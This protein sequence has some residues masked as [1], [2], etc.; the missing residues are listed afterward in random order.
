[1]KLF[2]YI[3]FIAIVCSI[4]LSFYGNVYSIS[5]KD[6]DT[7][8][9]QFSFPQPKIQNIGSKDFPI[10]R[11][12]LSDLPKQNTEGVP[13]LPVKPLR[14][15]LPMGRT[16]DTIHIIT[17]EK[18]FLGKYQEIEKGGKVLP[19]NILE[20]LFYADIKPLSRNRDIQKEEASLDNQNE[21]FSIVGVYIFRGYPTLH[22]N[23]HPI[24]YINKELYYYK[25]LKLE[26]TTKPTTY[27]GGF[28]GLE[29]DQH[30]V[31]EIIDNPEIISTYPANS[32]S[33]TQIQYVIITSKRF[34]DISED[35]TFQDLVYHKKKIGINATIV[36]V[37]DIISNPDF[38][39]NGKWGDNNPNNP[40]YQSPINGDPKKFDDVQA[41]IRNFI[42]YAYMEWGTDY[43]LLA[44]DA[45]TNNKKDNIVPLRGLFADERGLPLEGYASYE[46][47]DLPSDLYYACLDGNFNYDGDNHFG[48]AAKFNTVANI[49]EADLYAE[50]YVGRACVDR[51]I[52][53]SNFVQK[54]INYDDLYYDPYFKE[55]L[56][57]GESIGYQFYTNWGGDYKDVVAK[58]IPNEYNLSRLYDRDEPYH[59][60]NMSYYYDRLN[61]HPPIMINHD[62]HGSPTSALRLTCR[63]IESLNNTKYYFIY[64]QT[65]LAGSFD[66]CWPPSTYYDS[67]CIAEYFTVETPHGAIGVIM[68]SRYGL[69]SQE[70]I[71]SPSGAYDES[72]FK[73]IFSESI[74][75][76]GMANH[77][78]KE[79]NIWHIDENG[80][81]WACYE[82]NLFGDPQIKIKEPNPDI[83]LSINITRP[84]KGGYIYIND[85][86]PIPISFLNKPFILGN[87]TIIANA[88]SIPENMI[89][90]V[91][92]SIDNTT[93]YI[94]PNAPYQWTLSKIGRG[95]HTIT[96]K[97]NGKYNSTGEDK[98]QI[99]K[100]L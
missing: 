53:V 19:L 41:K 8:L 96:V 46:A 14:I 45:D 89:E 74:R 32:H 68:N 76:I 13:R 72:F 36:T 51:P 79:D 69:G 6:E 21:L 75:E 61:I 24:Q 54:I 12:N 37:E 16:I 80:M 67:D 28:R 92:F 10:F 5:Q 50:V 33:D 56:F 85:G 98:I 65:C 97:V 58:Y 86:D 4:N 87:I 20:P 26:I 39:V 60:W 15:L 47:M 100:I 70:T 11:V 44:G 42:R 90:S 57:L 9:L 25:S 31:R 78:S 43:I 52:E 1:M 71:D 88:T 93:L 73:A 38:S 3:L 94:D 2:R 22:I 66:N 18:V 59:H 95:L 83:N 81:R 48:E 29:K 77:Y 35:Y 17:G 55:I 49:D 82:T 63:A 40:F 27:K 62:G 23:L 64:S 30:L 7:I 99:Y 91:E 84:L 34:L